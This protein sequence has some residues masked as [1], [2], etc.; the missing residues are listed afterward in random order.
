MLTDELDGPYF[1]SGSDGSLYA[2]GMELFKDNDEYCIDYTLSEESNF[3]I[4]VRL[5]YCNVIVNVNPFHSPTA[6]R[7][8]MFP[9][10]A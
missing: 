10:G 9:I 5:S 6:Q 3:T 1:L 8:C 7:I 4:E 2:E